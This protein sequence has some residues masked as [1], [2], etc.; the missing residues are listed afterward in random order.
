MAQTKYTVQI[1]NGSQLVKVPGQNVAAFIQAGQVFMIQPEFTAY[2]V[3]ANATYNGV[4]TLF[5]LTGAYQGTTNAEATGIIVTGKTA[6][7]GIP[8]LSQG[9]VG[10]ATVFTLAMLRIEELLADVPTGGTVSGDV[11]QTMLTGFVTTNSPVT[12]GDNVLTAFGKLQGQQT[13][14]VGSGGAVH[15]VAT[16]TQHGFMA[17]VD[18]QK[19]DQLAPAFIGANPPGN[20]TSGQRWISTTNG[21]T[22]T[23]IL[24]GSA[25]AWITAI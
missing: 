22:Y 24:D 8:T 1:T 4:D 3:A 18:K 12:P 23:W 15:A 9:D 11:L 17:N 13:A 14:H 6:N 10:T 25:G 7:K 5:S 20:P 19:L 2:F 21:K 16:T